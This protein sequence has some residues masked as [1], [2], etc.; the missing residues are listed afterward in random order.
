MS[1][2]THDLT[3]ENV[4]G[5]FSLRPNDSDPAGAP[6]NN[7]AEAIHRF[8]FASPSSRPDDKSFSDS[9]RGPRQM[10]SRLTPR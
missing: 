5:K 7:Q 6:F 9:T 1:T 2:A 10:A 8:A 4:D 3:Q